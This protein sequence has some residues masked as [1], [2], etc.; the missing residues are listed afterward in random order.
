[1]E[2]QRLQSESSS[3]KE[4][5]NEIRLMDVHSSSSGEM[6]RD[7]Y[8]DDGRSH[9]NQAFSL[10]VE[11][12]VG[13]AHLRDYPKKR[14]KMRS[15]STDFAFSEANEESRIEISRATTAKAV[16]EFLMP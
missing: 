16:K 10:P 9:R 6:K 14:K 11:K 15:N 4:S 2:Y 13:K 12:A 8:S 3:N 1:M 5:V 7:E